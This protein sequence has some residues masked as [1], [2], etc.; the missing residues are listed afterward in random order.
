MSRAA[1]KIARNCPQFVGK[2]DS[3]LRQDVCVSVVDVVTK[4]QANLYAELLARFGRA[5]PRLGD[6]PAALYA[7][8]L[9]GRKLKKRRAVLDLWCFPLT[10]GQPLPTIPLWLSPD[11]RID[12]PL[13][14]SYQEV[15]RLLRIA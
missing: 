8:T 2:L 10:L 3:L 11:L 14:P 7:A 6:P 4:H 15:C 13:E 5:D 1:R 12:L 9:R